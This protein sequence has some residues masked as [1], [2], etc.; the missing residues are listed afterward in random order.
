VP[1]KTKKPPELKSAG[2]SFGY[3]E[4][5]TPS[6]PNK[7]PEL[8]LQKESRRF[9]PHAFV[10]NSQYRRIVSTQRQTKLMGLVYDSAIGRIQTRVLGEQR[11]V[12]PRG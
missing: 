2:G 9:N 1:D 11:A 10:S 12:P 3:P 7:F 4:I 6:S 5:L 8:I